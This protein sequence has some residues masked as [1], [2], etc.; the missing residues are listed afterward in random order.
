MG[1]VTAAQRDAAAEAKG[2]FAEHFWTDRGRDALEVA[3]GTAASKPN[4]GYGG[5]GDPMDC[6]LLSSE[7]PPCAEGGRKHG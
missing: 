2:V 7:Q 5:L 6:P 4:A 1:Y 3:Y